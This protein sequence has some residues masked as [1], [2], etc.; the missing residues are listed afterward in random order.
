MQ[1]P[2]QD[3]FRAILRV[4]NGK[5]DPMFEE[6]GV[7]LEWNLEM[8]E[9]KGTFSIPIQGRIDSE[10]GEYIVLAQNFVSD[11]PANS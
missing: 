9:L 6:Y 1:T 5:K 7:T 11:P 3:L 10:S 8:K 2:G 4:S